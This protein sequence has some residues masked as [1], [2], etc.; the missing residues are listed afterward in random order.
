MNPSLRACLIVVGIAALYGLVGRL[1]FAAEPLGQWLRIVSIS[2]IFLTPASLGALVCFTGSKLDRPSNF[3]ALI[4]PAV[5]MIVL[6]LG[7]VL[8]Q[9]EAILCV[10]VAAPVAVPMACVGGWLMSLVL[11][12][13]D[14]SRLPLSFAVLLPYAV[15]PLE[16]LWNTPHE[17]QHIHNTVTIRATPEVIWRH[18]QQVEPILPSELPFQ[19]IY[20]LDF[21]RPVAATLDRPEVGGRRLATFERGVSFFEVVTEWR[22]LHRLSFTI[23]A[24]PAFIPSTAF[25]QHIIIGGRF[26]D[27]LHGAYEIRPID[28]HFSILHLSSAHRL[29]TPFNRYTGWWSAWVMDQIQGSILEVIRKRCETSASNPG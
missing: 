8:F 14:R 11:K 23:E 9:L 28:D 15:S 12:R 19:W 25:D 26:Y 2:F 5:T 13:I 17:T 1:L 22:P 6:L 20:L 27:V 7:S 24:D 21:P 18:I 10:L 4:A 16:Q 29:S 3:W